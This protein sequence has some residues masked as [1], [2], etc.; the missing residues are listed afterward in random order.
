[1]CRM[2]VSTRQIYIYIYWWPAD[3]GVVSYRGGVITS[4]TASS[5][6]WVAKQFSWNHLLMVIISIKEWETTK[7]KDL[8][9]FKRI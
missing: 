6:T 8:M 1:M 3:A 2:A 7:K 4:V 9:G 5:E